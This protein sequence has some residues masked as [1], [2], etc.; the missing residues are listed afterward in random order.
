MRSFFFF[1]FSR[2]FFFF[3][4]V[5]FFPLLLF[6]KK[7]C[8]PWYKNDPK[9][10][11]KDEPTKAKTKKEMKKHNPSFPS[12]QT[13]NSS[14]LSPSAAFPQPGPRGWGALP[15]AQ[16]LLSVLAGGTDSSPPPLCLLHFVLQV[17]RLLPGTLL[18]LLLFSHPLPTGSSLCPLGGQE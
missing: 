15:L 4:R 9:L 2:V 14:W 5:F 10:E 16:L 11:N 3:R 1:L 13:F 12:P 8:S 7:A 6:F 18:L 17:G